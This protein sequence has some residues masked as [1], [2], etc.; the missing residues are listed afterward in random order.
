VSGAASQWRELRGEVSMVTGEPRSKRQ[1]KVAVYGSPW[2]WHRG[3]WGDNRS[4]K[5]GRQ[6]G[7]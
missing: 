4:R 6:R 2:Q 1:A 5:H 7:R 3:L